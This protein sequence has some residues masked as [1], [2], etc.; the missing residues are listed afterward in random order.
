MSV[1][2]DRISMREG[3]S[4]CVQVDGSAELCLFLQVLNKSLH[5]QGPMNVNRKVFELTSGGLK[6]KKKK[7]KPKK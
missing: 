4:I 3:N 2:L 1:P 6:E 7:G 5:I